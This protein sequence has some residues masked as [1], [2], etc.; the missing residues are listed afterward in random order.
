M[1][2]YTK[3]QDPNHE[4]SPKDWLNLCLVFA[5][6]LS[7]LLKETEGIVVD[8]K[9]NIKLDDDAKKVIVF[10]KDEQIHIYPITDGVNETNS[11]LPEGT[12]IWM[13]PISPN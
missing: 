11:D 7:C 6:V 9:G 12:M 5:A 3:P 8:I 10:K 4:D 2:N 1:A 13:T